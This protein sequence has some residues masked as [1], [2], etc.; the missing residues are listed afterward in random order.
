M[1]GVGFIGLGQMG[2][3]MAGHLVEHTGG[4][5]VFDV[6]PETATDL[7]AAGGRLATSVAETAACS[8]VIEIMV[9]DDQQVMD[10]CCGPDGVLAHAPDHA[11]VAIHS[12][13]HP[14]TAMELGRLAHELR[15]TVSFVDAPVS[16]GF[17][18][19]L[20]ASLAVMVGGESDAV[21]M[22][23]PV[24]ERWAGLVIH[25]GPLGAGTRAK[26]ARNLLHFTSFTAANEAQRLAEAYGIDLRKLAKV[27]RHTDRITGGA[28][29]IMLRDT[30]TPLAPGDEWY[31][32]LI[33]VRTLG[34]KDLSLALELA[35]DVGL[36]L[37]LGT[38]ALEAF[39]GSLGLASGRDIVSPSTD[40]P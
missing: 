19:A 40:R 26:L 15:P 12:T 27:I 1:A 38:V 13:I 2:A 28:S 32:T 8:N 17:I 16:G 10:V 37:P 5:T 39:A 35:E 30:T 20:D 25:L 21:E 6:K 11:V 18:G 31:E 29:S 4:L 22:C 23:R 33:H 36:D 3:A 24:F 34:E 14:R 9:L 7:V